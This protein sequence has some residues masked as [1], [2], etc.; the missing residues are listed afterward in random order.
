MEL[1][2]DEPRR[3][4]ALESGDI[5]EGRRK[6][7]G[8]SLNQVGG[9]ALNERGRRRRPCGSRGGATGGGGSYSRPSTGVRGG[10]SCGRAVGLRGMEGLVIDRWDWWGWWLV[11]LNIETFW[12][13]RSHG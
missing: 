11:V 7:I 5:M 1:E 2:S 8:L 3:T 6:L 10:A 13:F 4:L 12:T 9:R